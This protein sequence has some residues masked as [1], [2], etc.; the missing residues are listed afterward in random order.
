MRNG[1]GGRGESSKKSQEYDTYGVIYVT[2]LWLMLLSLL[3]KLR[4]PCY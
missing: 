1:G 2:F 3:I 4:Y